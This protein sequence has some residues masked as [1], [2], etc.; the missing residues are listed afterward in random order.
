M[1]ALFQG[2]IAAA[3]LE[4]GDGDPA[5]TSK[6]SFDITYN[7]AGRDVQVDAKKDFCD[8]KNDGRRSGRASLC[9]RWA[10]RRRGAD[11]F[12]LL[13]PLEC[14]KDTTVKAKRPTSKRGPD[15]KK[16]HSERSPEM[17]MRSVRTHLY[18]DSHGSGRRRQGP[19]DPE[20]DREEGPEQPAEAAASEEARIEAEKSSGGRG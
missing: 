19:G 18:G 2:L 11:L 5:G 10:R 15:V 7:E 4:G 9:F 3:F 8:K 16:S 1:T 6:P 20:R 14:W 12:S 17:L 13:D